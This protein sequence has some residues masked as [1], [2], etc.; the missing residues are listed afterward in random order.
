MTELTTTERD[1][2]EKL[3]YCIEVCMC[4]YLCCS[5]YETKLFVF[6]ILRLTALTIE[7]LV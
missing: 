3:R 5:L 2:V 6:R 1:Y 4:V 7:I